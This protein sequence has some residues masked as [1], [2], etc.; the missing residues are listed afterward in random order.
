MDLLAK[1][2]KNRTR[3]VEIEGEVVLVRVY[4][5]KEIEK[6]GVDLAKPDDKKMAIFLSKQFLHENGEEVFTPE[7]FMTEACTNVFTVELAKLWRDVNSG[8]YKK[9]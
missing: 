8:A 6:I 1:I 4:A 9:K 3:P 7:F 2:A 5:Q